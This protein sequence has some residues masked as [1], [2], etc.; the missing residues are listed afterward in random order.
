MAGHS[1]SSTASRDTIS[2]AELAAALE[3]QNELTKRIRAL[4]RRV[5]DGARV[6]PGP[7]TI[8]IEAYAEV[9]GDGETP[10]FGLDGVSIDGPAEVPTA[11]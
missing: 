10:G 9:E 6:E 2:Q 3:L 5:R 1:T 11:A 7:F 8:S 4:G